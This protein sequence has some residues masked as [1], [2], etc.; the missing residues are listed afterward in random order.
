MQNGVAVLSVAEGS[1]FLSF[2]KRFLKRDR[3]PLFFPCHSEPAEESPNI[4]AKPIIQG[5]AITTLTL[6]PARHKINAKFK[7]QKAKFDRK[8]IFPF[9]PFKAVKNII[10]TKQK[11]LIIAL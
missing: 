1:F 3:I 2:W 6:V 5:D 9:Y 7:M 4:N 11:A 8:K 10:K